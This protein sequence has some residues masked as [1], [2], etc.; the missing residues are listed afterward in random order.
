M[1]KKEYQ[2]AEAFMLAHPE[3]GMPD[4]SH[5]YR[6]LDNALL[7]CREEPAADCDVVALAAL[8]HDVGKAAPQPGQGHAQTGAAMVYEFLQANGYPLRVALHVRDCVASHSK[9]GGVEPKSIEA[10]I[11]YDADKLDLLGAVGLARG[12]QY[13]TLEGLPLYAMDTAGH[14]LPGKAGEEPSLLQAARKKIKQ[15][16]EGFYTAAGQAAAERRIETM[17]RVIKMG[18]KEVK[19]SNKKGK[20]LLKSLFEEK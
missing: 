4:A 6:V 8:L 17:Q 12:L 16:S 1:K 13:G 14:A 10:K 2:L 11:I 5:I 19:K 18:K 3:P 7:L 20:K 9:N 15:G